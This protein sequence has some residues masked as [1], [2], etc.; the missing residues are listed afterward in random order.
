MRLVENQ[1][2]FFFPID[3]HQFLEITHYS[4]DTEPVFREGPLSENQIS[5][6]LLQATVRALQDTWH[7][8]NSYFRAHYEQAGMVT[9]FTPLKSS[10][11]GFIF[12]SDPLFPWAYSLC[13]IH[14]WATQRTYALC[15]GLWEESIRELLDYL[16]TS[17]ALSMH[18]LFVS[19]A[20]AD[21]SSSD[22]NTRNKLVQEDLEEVSIATKTD[23][24]FYVPD[25]ESAIHEDVDFVKLTLQLTSLSSSCANLTALVSTE[26]RV[27]TLSSEI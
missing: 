16:R 21:L 18:P 20:I 23:A 2:N 3:G 6:W 26:L 14:D 12:Q 19:I 27:S 17:K 9:T 24:P 8:P 25:E 4:D 1:E 15:M 10:S 13:I 5:D 11:I 22:I 7:V